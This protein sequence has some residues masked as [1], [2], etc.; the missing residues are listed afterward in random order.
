LKLKNY[1]RALEF[2]CVEYPIGKATGDDLLKKRL[3][4]QMKLKKI[5]EEEERR[6]I[7][8]ERARQ[9]RNIMGVRRA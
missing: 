1:D 2:P 7:E 3:A 5:R 8:E 9:R 4:E 6:R